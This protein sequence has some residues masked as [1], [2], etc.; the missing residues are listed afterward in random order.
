MILLAYAISLPPPSTS[1]TPTTIDT[2]TS[3]TPTINTSTSTTPTLTTPTDTPTDTYTPIIL[4]DT[5]T[6]DN[7]TP[8]P[9]TPSNNKRQ[10]TQFPTFDDNYLTNLIDTAHRNNVSVRIK[11]FN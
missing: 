4:I 3:T 6:I 1:T 9:N 5:P 11:I 7:S 8:T 10:S 2:S